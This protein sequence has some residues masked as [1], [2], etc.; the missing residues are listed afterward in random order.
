MFP[1]TSLIFCAIMLTLQSISAQ[2]YNTE[3]EAKIDLSTN[4]EFYKINCFAN[5]K[6]FINRSLH[7]VFTLIRNEEGNTSSDKQE[8]DF[9]LSAEEKRILFSNTVNIQKKDRVILLLLIYDEDKNILGKDRIAVNEVD[10]DQDFKK[11]ILK[12]NQLSDDL[13][14]EGEDG[15]VVL[16]GVVVENTITRPGREFFRLYDQKYRD[17]GIDGEKIITV[18]EVLALGTNTKIQVKAE[19]E[20]IFQFFVNPRTDYIEEMVDYALQ[21]TDLYF[22]QLAR[23]RN[24]VKKY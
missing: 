17:K 9:V 20:I 4:G 13:N 16:K 5:N 2:I 3:V 19:S 15:I 1:K 12:N 7:Y 24:L 14:R 10:S 6:T 11:N 18:E 22:R 21:N 23:N 8:G